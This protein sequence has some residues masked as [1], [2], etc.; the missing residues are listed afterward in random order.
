MTTFSGDAPDVV[1]HKYHDAMHM[2][3][4]S[5]PIISNR[6]YGE[7]IHVLLFGQEIE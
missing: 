2:L 1:P 5:A 3:G 4:R 6:A 7:F